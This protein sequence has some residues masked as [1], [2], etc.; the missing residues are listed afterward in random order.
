MFYL[1]FER[2]VLLYKI[3]EQNT[4]HYQVKVKNVKVVGSQGWSLV[5]EGEAEKQVNIP[6]LV[7]KCCH[8]SW[9]NIDLKWPIFMFGLF[10]AEAICCTCMDLTSTRG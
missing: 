8:G 4:F 3:P 5:R 9:L 7:T 10:H 6:L 2:S 1:I